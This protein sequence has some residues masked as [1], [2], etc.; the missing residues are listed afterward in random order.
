MTKFVP[1][2]QH[3][4]KQLSDA[5]GEDAVFDISFGV[6]YDESDLFSCMEHNDA[7]LIKHYTFELTCVCC[8]VMIRINKEFH[9]LLN[10]NYFM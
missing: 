1:N 5:A 7:R 6:S 4:S 9:S 8:S 2:K 10:V 3:S